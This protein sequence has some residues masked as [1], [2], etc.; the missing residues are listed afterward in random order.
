MIKISKEERIALRQM[1]D[2]QYKLCASAERIIEK[3]TIT[4]FTYFWAALNGERRKNGKKPIGY[5]DAYDRWIDY[6]TT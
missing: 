3:S 5:G 2:A 4:P 1:I 6:T